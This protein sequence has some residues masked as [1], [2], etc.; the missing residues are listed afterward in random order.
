MNEVKL[1]LILMLSTSLSLF[2]NHQL[3]TPTIACRDLETASRSKPLSG[4]PDALLL[5]H[6]LLSKSDP[7]AAV[8]CGV[9]VQ[10][11]KV[12]G[13][14]FV[15]PRLEAESSLINGPCRVNGEALLIPQT[16]RLKFK[17]AFGV[18]Q[19]RVLRDKQQICNFYAVK[20]LMN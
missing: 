19:E 12:G 6:M 7:L 1:M 4:T 18:V 8:E 10:V 9:P 17:D 2:L 11:A 16:A 15:N 3:L 5:V 13:E 14:I 20:L